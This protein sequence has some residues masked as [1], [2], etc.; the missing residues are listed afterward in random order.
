MVVWGILSL[1]CVILFD[2]CLVMDFSGAEKFCMRVGLLSGQVFS[3]F[4]GQRSRSQ[5]TKTCLAKTHPACIRMVCAHSKR[6]AAAACARSGQ[7]HFLADEGWQ[8]AAV[9]IGVSELL[10]RLSGAFGIGS[11]GVDQGYMVGFASCKPAQA[12]V[13]I[14]NYL[15]ALHFW[16]FCIYY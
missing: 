4:G 2:L 1:L 12:L 5:G 7:A 8:R 15:C 14:N 6:Q 13:F 10:T 11:A 3:H 16:H 9:R